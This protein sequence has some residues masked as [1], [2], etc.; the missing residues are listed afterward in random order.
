MF[1]CLQYRQIVLNVELSS[2]A[3]ASITRALKYVAISN[4]NKQFMGFRNVVRTF[5]IQLN[6]DFG[7]TWLKTNKEDEHDF[8]PHVL[9]NSI[10][11]CCVTALLG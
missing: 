6:D 1:R 5:R 4:I 10:S 7:R 3:N 11:D 2:Y 8:K 9:F